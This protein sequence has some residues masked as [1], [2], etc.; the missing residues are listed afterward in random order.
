V[1]GHK[2]ST[3]Y[4]LDLLA[5]APE[6][7]K[8]SPPIRISKRLQRTIKKRG[9]ATGDGSEDGSGEL[10]VVEETKPS[11]FDRPLPLDQ[12]TGR[13]HVPVL[14]SAQ[15][16]PVLRLKKPQPLKLSSYLNNRIEQRQKRHNLRH[17]IED[18]LEIAKWEDVWDRMMADASADAGVETHAGGGKKD[19]TWSLELYKGRKEINWILD[20]E[21]V[22]NR[23]MAEKLQGVV[24]R[25]R[26][27]FDAEK[28]ARRRA[29]ASR[30]QKMR[31]QRRG[32]GN[33][34]LD[35]DADRG[36]DL[37]PDENLQA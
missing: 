35:V 8:Q 21:R 10:A 14:F 4:I 28:V 5:R 2:G 27:L 13:R 20:G 34:A 31:R 16:I 15:G 17:R 12:L 11:L 18:E 3:G 30:V 36:S 9:R 26:E 6:R 19:P 23:E 29:K 24:D 37:R 1:A 7:V 32:E 25:E 33:A 22:K